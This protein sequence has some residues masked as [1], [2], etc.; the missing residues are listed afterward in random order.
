[1]IRANARRMTRDQERTYDI[2]LLMR[3]FRAEAMAYRAQVRPLAPLE[4][5]YLSSAEGFY[6]PRLGSALLGL[7][8]DERAVA[9][10]G[11]D[12]LTWLLERCDLR[13]VIPARLVPDQRR[14]FY[15]EHLTRYTTYVQQYPDRQESVPLLERVLLHLAQHVGAR[16]DAAVRPAEATGAG[17]YAASGRRHGRAPSVA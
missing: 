16:I 14:R 15:L 4:F 10:M 5:G 13:Y 1:M 9:R 17:P 8:L 11:H 3:R 7:R 2:Y 6:S 12:S